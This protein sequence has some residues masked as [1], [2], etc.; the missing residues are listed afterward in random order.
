[1]FLHHKNTIL[2]R[3]VVPHLKN[4]AHPP[5]TASRGYG[6]SSPLFASHVLPPIGTPIPTATPLYRGAARLCAYGFVGSSRR[7]LPFARIRL[8]YAGS[9]FR[10]RRLGQINCR[11]EGFSCA[12]FFARCACPLAA[13]LR[14]VVGG[15]G[16]GLMSCNVLSR[17]SIF[18]LHSPHYKI[19]VLYNWYL[20]LIHKYQ[21]H[22]VFFS[23]VVSWFSAEK[24]GL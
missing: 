4:P 6:L 8:R 11:R 18:Y 3:E 2:R 10:S 22:A 16:Q 1:M 17:S 5:P 15:L 19:R 21:L 24:N 14:G 9:V 20:W 12:R 23:S 7:R 13:P